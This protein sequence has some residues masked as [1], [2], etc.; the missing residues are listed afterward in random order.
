MGRG[1]HL[2]KGEPTNEERARYDRLASLVTLRGS[3]AARTPLDA[4]LAAW[5]RGVL[6]ET[7]GAP[8]IV[9][10]MMGGSVPTDKLV[11]AL[12]IPFVIIPLVNGDN[13]QH[14]ADENLRVGHYL[15]GVK[16]FVGLIRKAYPA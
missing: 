8:P 6:Q 13:N 15:D 1:Y 3:T 2:V 5:A 16:T 14:T 10:R 11:G 7:F 9:I 4:P 12:G